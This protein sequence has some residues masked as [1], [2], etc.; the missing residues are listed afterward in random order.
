MLLA[1]LN[2]H[3]QQYKTS[4]LHNIQSNLYVDNA[5]MGCDSELQDL[6]FYQQARS[7]LF[8]ARFYLR[9]R[10]PNSQLLMAAAQQDG[11]AD[12]NRLTNVLE[13]QWNT[14]TD[15]TSLV[16]KGLHPMSSSPKAKQVVLQYSLKLFDLGIVSPVSVHAKLLTQQLWQ[17]CI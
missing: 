12:G 7:M 13:V 14:T 10:T 9:A 5:V 1:V 16:L 6:Q 2:R 17:Q 4:T 11:T 8:E 3:L 15:K